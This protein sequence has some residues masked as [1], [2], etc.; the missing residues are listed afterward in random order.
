MDKQDM[1]LGGPGLDGYA[2]KAACYCVPCGRAAILALPQEE[3]DDVLARDSDT[4]PQPIFFG[5]SDGPVHCDECGEHLYGEELVE[6]QAK[7]VTE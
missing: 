7:E 6:E 4:V 3:Y 2:Y 1:L 5:E